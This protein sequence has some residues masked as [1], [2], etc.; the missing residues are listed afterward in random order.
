MKNDRAGRVI[1]LRL[2]GSRNMKEAR[3]QVHEQA[4]R[5]GD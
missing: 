3:K 1:S 5:D 4:R 2:F